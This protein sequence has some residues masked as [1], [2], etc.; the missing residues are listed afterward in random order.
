MRSP[1]PQAVATGNE[2]PPLPGTR[3]QSTVSIHKLRRFNILILVFRFAAFCFSLAAA[4]FMLTNS[5]GSDLPRW[6]DFEAYRYT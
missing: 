4:I 3:F 5:K 6:Q 2:T 1:R